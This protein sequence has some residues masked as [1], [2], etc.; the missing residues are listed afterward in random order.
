MG[1]RAPHKYPNDFDQISTELFVCKANDGVLKS[2]ALAPRS[3][4]SVRAG[5][6]E[7]RARGN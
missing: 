5:T 4:E 2:F 7:G 6:G 1:L 3:G